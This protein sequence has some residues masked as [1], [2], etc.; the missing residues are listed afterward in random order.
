VPE[1]AEL[2][3]AVAGTHGSWTHTR[4]TGALAIPGAAGTRTRAREFA[5]HPD[6]LKQLPVGTAV[7]IG[8]GELPRRTRIPRPNTAHA[9]IE[10]A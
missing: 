8:A 9:R 10:G 7:V 6:E 1:S 5:V 4:R 2:I 3:A